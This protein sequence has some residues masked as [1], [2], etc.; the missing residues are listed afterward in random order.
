M[1][2]ADSA[3]IS[4]ARMFALAFGESVIPAPPGSRVNADAYAIPDYVTNKLPQRGYP[5]MVSRRQCLAVSTIKA[6]ASASDTAADTRMSC[7][8]MG[9]SLSTLVINR[10][11]LNEGISISDR[12]V[13]RE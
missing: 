4:N 2:A 10:C 12:W 8:A 6:N 7:Q 11:W 9:S 13:R 5:S 3:R 1:M